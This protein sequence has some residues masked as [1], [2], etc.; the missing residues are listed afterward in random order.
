MFG[1]HFEDIFEDKE[2][3]K[4]IRCFLASDSTDHTCYFLLELLRS[5]SSEKS[6]SLKLRLALIDLLKRKAF[7]DAN[8]LIRALFNDKDE[9]FRELICSILG[10]SKREDL[11]DILIKVLNEE[12]SPLVRKSAVESLENIKIKAAV[13]YLKK[14][15][16]DSEELWIVRE[17]A[18]GVLKKVL[19]KPE[20]EAMMDKLYNDPEKKTLLFEL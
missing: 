14:I 1:I 6:K 11:E 18:A 4:E 2:A 7:R 19:G 9:R 10:S 5:T 8:P 17:R 15:V 3:L 20:F 12:K 16:D 13:P